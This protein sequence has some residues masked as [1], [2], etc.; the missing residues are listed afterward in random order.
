MAYS[1]RKRATSLPRVFLDNALLCLQGTLAQRALQEGAAQLPLLEPTTNIFALAANSLAVAGIA[2]NI[3][4][5]GPRWQRCM[6]L[7]RVPCALQLVK[8]VII[9]KMECL[10]GLSFCSLIDPVQRHW[11]SRLSWCISTPPSARSQRAL[12]QGRRSTAQRQGWRPLLGGR[13]SSWRLPPRHTHRAQQGCCSSWLALWRLSSRVLL[14]PAPTAAQR[15][16]Q[17]RGVS[18]AAQVSPKGGGS[19]AS[20]SSPGVRG[21]CSVW[22][23]LRWL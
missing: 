20:C 2:G 3:C 1:L 14:L 6:L 11:A 22:T 17:P 7:L 16:L 4:R 23:P 18:Q 5:P 12:Q 9:S 21:C 19:G 13:R 8:S 10:H 15:G